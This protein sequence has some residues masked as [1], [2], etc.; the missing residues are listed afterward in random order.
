MEAKK[1]VYFRRP[2]QPNTAADVLDSDASSESS[3]EEEVA[4][5]KQVLSAPKIDWQRIDLTEPFLQRWINL[6]P[7]DIITSLMADLRR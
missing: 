7:P 6:M 5:E 2:L 1:V 3:E 4:P